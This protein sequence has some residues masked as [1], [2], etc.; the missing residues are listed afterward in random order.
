MTELVLSFILIILAF[1]SMAL[2]LLCGRK[3]ICVSCGALNESLAS[4]HEACPGGGC[5]T[6]SLKRST[7]T[8]S[9]TCRISD[10]HF[11]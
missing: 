1:T 8:E 2:G 11:V 4:G 7:V 6:T 9:K 3:G 10:A 5:R